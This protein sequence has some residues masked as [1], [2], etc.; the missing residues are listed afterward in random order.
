M[1]KTIIFLLFYAFTF[2]LSAQSFFKNTRLSVGFAVQAQ[3]RRLFDLSGRADIIKREDSKLD[4]E[5]N[6]L[7]QKPIMQY[8]RFMITTGLGYSQWISRFSRPFDHLRILR[9]KSGDERGRYIGNYHI[10]KMMVPVTTRLYIDQKSIFHAQISTLLAIS[11]NRIITEKTI[12]KTYSR[13]EFTPHSVEINP[14]IG[15]ILWKKFELNLNYRVLYVSELDNV[16]FNSILFKEDDPEFL[17]QKTD[18]YNPF[19]LWLSVGYVF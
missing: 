13:W 11:F 1:R 12:D 9:L 19:K 7:F 6:I 15:I 16:I 17:Q 3:D 5:Y 10:H 2:N 18:T 8:K 4:Y 14:G